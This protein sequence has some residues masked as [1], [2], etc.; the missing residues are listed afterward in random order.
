[1]REVWEGREGGKSR[2]EEEVAKPVPMMI[3]SQ[4]IL[5]DGLLLLH[6]RL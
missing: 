3:E 6:Y 1:M 2:R 4:L 5:R